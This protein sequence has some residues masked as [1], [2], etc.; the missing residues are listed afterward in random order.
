[1]FDLQGHRGARGLFPENTLAGFAGAVAAGVTSV[2]LDIAI[3]ADGV[4]VVVH[5]PVLDPDLTRDETGAWI[6]GAPLRVGAM[7]LAAE[8]R[9]AVGRAR[10]GGPTARAFPSQVPRDGQRVPTLAD[11]FA[12]TAAAGIPVHAELK[13]D[14]SAPWLTVP[15]ARMAEL[16]VAAARDAGALPRLSVRSFDWRGVAWLRR[17]APHVPLCWLTDAETEAAAA[18][19][20]GQPADGLATPQ[21]VA[22]AAFSAGPMSWAPVWAP[23]HT[24]LRPEHVAEARSLGLRVVPWTVNAPRDIARLIGCGVTGICTDRPDLAHRVI[25]DAEPVPPAR[26]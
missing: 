20:W 11:V 15:P 7:T 13:T 12:A 8:R 17:A 25:A 3:T 19:W 10:P 22:R 9:C 21:A 2:E 26:P 16:V 6:T 14:P 4:P 23:D 5:A 1:M 18:L 24:G